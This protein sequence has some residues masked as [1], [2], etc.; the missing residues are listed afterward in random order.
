MLARNRVRAH[1]SNDA[2]ANLFGVLATQVVSRM[3][4]EQHRSLAIVSPT[5]GVGKSTLAANLS[6]AIARRESSSVLLVD[7]DLR[8]PSQASLFGVPA[9][10][11]IEDCLSC[12]LS[13]DAASIGFS[14]FPRLALLPGVSG[15]NNVEEVLNS[16]QM[17]RLLEEIQENPPARWVI[18]DLPPIL[19]LSDALTL[20]PKFD[21]VLL[22]VEEFLTSHADLE[23]AMRL[24]DETPLAG[25]VIN[26]SF[27]NPGVDYGVRNYGSDSSNAS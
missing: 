22:V 2:M 15:C 14:Q 17:D 19:G 23:E 27:S 10:Q 20:M 7:L 6:I 9:Q 8:K 25:Y 1:L 13:L 12:N 21:A 3:K 11:G 24:I 4:A 5:S 26:K 18:Y 16:M